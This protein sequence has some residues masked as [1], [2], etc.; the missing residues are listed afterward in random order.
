M[1]ERFLKLLLVRH[2]EAIGNVEKRMLG[3]AESPLSDRGQ[4]QATQL[5]QALFHQGWQPTHLYSSPLQRAAKTAQMAWQAYQA[6]GSSVR[7]EACAGDL[8]PHWKQTI[9]Y[10]DRLQEIDI[11]CLQ[12]LTWAEAK[13]AY[14]QLCES[15]EASLVLVPISGAESLV[16]IRAR[17]RAFIATIL[18]QH[19]NGDRLWVFTHSA[20]LT[21][22][23]SELLGMERSWKLEIANTAVFEFWLDCD[24]WS[25]RD[26]N[27]YNT[28]LWHI[29]RFNQVISI[30]QL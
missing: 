18:Q 15:L 4:A 21:H 8:T 1:T 19:Q 6:M 27:L 16:A 14:P 20:L 10:D 17:S 24:R 29:R 11:G 13:T 5:G 12:G 7:D 25:L 23:I 30:P 3:Q 2:A 26:E 22:L 28:E 9:I